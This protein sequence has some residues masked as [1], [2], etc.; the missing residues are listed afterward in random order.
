MMMITITIIALLI[1]FED[2]CTK[3]DQTG[4]SDG[5]V[6]TSGKQQGFTAKY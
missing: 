5:N 6:L 1:L 2:H 4:K 3:M